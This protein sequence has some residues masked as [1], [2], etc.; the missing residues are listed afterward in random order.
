MKTCKSGRHSYEG[1]HCKRCQNER[2]K[3]WH[4]RNP[5]KL[6]GSQLKIK[7]WPK[8]TSLEAVAEYNKLLKRQSNVCAICKRPE[9]GLYKKGELTRNKDL[10]VDHCHKTNK[11]RGLLCQKCNHAVG[12]LQNNPDICR[13][14]A[15]YLESSQR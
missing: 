1:R 13:M 8:L 4:K 5:H 14:A 10:A 9:T 7:Y 6:R 11:V 3:E 2:T 12:L 15:N